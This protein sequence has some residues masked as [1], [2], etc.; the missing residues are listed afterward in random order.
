MKGCASVG[1]NPGLCGMLTLG[2]RKY[3]EKLTRYLQLLAVL[4]A[5][6]CYDTKAAWLS[7]LML[8]LRTQFRGVIPSLLIFTCYGRSAPVWIVATLLD[9]H[10]SRTVTMHYTTQSNIKPLVYRQNICTLEPEPDTS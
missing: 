9:R 4:I 3:C 2:P 1:I 6:K 10:D 5:L 8:G 7:R